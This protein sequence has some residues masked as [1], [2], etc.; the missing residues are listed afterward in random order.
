MDKL[1]IIDRR[2]LYQLDLNSRQSFT[3]IGK[4]VRLR[5][6]LVAY[7][8]KRMQQEGIITGF[9]TLIDSYKLGY[10]V[11]RFYVVFQYVT[12][13]IKK[14]IITYL[15]KDKR[16]WV[17]ESIIGKYDL[18]VFVWV[19][20]VREFY[21]F[22]EKFLDAYGDYFAERVF[23]IYVQGFSYPCRYL[24]SEHSDEK[25]GN[26][27]EKICGG[28]SKV[29]I[30]EYDFR[31]LNL[32]AENTRMLLVDLAGELHSSTQ[33]VHQRLQKLLKNDVI[34]AFRVGLDISQL[35]LKP[36]KVDVYFHERTHRQQILEFIKRDPHL[37][38]IGTSAG[39]SDL[40][41]EFD[42]KDSDDIYRIMELIKQKFPNA[43]RKYEYF[44][45]EKSHKLRF[46]PEIW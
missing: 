5:K 23:S 17:V 28:G 24:I 15:V 7:R 27:D 30:D 2:I 26:V 39:S 20:D 22:W 32:L 33:M 10:I 36:F 38:F 14:E 41:L 25:S 35:G 34:Q 44:S 37:V 3:Q 11:F 1:D 9:W 31:L 19:K 4:K 46:L 43:V 18:G 29:D 6:N 45:I 40:E 12:P 42:L 8:I 13:S 16:T 21:S